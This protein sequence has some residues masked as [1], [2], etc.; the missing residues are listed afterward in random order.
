MVNILSNTPFLISPKGER[1]VSPSPLGEVPIAI[2][3]VGGLKNKN[4]LLL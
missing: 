4:R 3:R 1:M 2:G